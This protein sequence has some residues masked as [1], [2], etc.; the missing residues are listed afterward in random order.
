MWL[1]TVDNFPP[2][3]NYQLILQK[4]QRTISFGKS[5]EIRRKY[6]SERPYLKNY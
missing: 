5:S 3:P 6:T 1:L 4:N 2:P